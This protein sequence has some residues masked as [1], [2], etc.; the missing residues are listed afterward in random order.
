MEDRQMSSDYQVEETKPVA[1]A[2]DL[3]L[4]VLN[5]L[6]SPARNAFWVILALAVAVLVGLVFCLYQ[7]SLNNTRQLYLLAG[8]TGYLFFASITGAIIVRRGRVSLAVWLVLVSLQVVIAL[9]PL[10][11][12]GLGLWYALLVV[13]LTLGFTSLCMPPQRMIL[14]NILG[15]VAALAILVIDGFVTGLQMTPDRLFGYFLI[16]GV[17]ILA[18]IDLLI[19]IGYFPAYSLRAKIT[20]TVFS[21]AILSIGLLS[22]A[23][24]I[25]TRRALID[26]TDQTLMLAARETARDIDGYFL[27]LMDRLGD[28]AVAPIWSNFLSLPADQRTSEVTL[29]A[30]VYL[31]TQRSLAGAATYA[32]VDQQGRVVLYTLEEDVS[33]V[34]P[35]LGLPAKVQNLLMQTM[36]SGEVYISPV[37]FPPTGEPPFFVVAAQIRNATEQPLGILVASFTLDALQGIVTAGN[38][39]AGDG[40]YAVLFDENNLRIAHGRDPQSH[41]LLLVPPDLQVH[42]NLVDAMRIPNLSYREVTTNYLDFGQGLASLDETPYFATQDSANEGETNSAAAIRLNYRPWVLAFLQPQSVILAPVI[43]Q[44]RIT[45]LLAAVV[46][47]LAILAASLLARLVAEPIVR[48]TSIAER[49]AGG[50]LYLQASVQSPDEI[51]TLGSAFNS[52]IN[53]LRHT[54]EGLESRVKDRTTELVDT[55]QQM[56]YRANRL[57]MVADVAHAIAAVQDPRALL[58]RVTEEIS[59]R[60]G[61]YHVGVF[62]IDAERKFAVLQAANSP[63]GKRMLARNHRLRVGEVGI[64]G[65]VAGTGQARIALDVGKDA[66][67]FTNPD[68]PDTR[69]EISLPLKV[70]QEV[71]GVLDVQ[72]VVAGAFSQD[73][74]ALLSALA[75]QV[76]MAIQNTR[77]Y[78]ETRRTLRELQVVQRQY[79]QEMWGK[80]TRE[81]QV[82][83]FEV[84]FGQINPLQDH[85]DGDLALADEGLEAFQIS[86][87]EKGKMVIP[88][89]L[90]GQVIGVIDLQ[91]SGPGRPWSREEIELARA[92]ADQVGLALENARLLEETQRRAERER[93]VA[94]ITTKMRATNDPQ[95]IMETALAE[96]RSALGIKSIQVRLQTIEANLSGEKESGDG[97]KEV[98][99]EVRGDA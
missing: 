61:Y 51:G 97:T 5:R 7:A 69:S 64:V 18:V 94:D 88:I 62:L 77:L 28:Q 30:R 9:S 27:E 6:A 8:L 71:I 36:A 19:L 15:V 86:V 80:M 56:E 98:D 99:P 76:A 47:G 93:M 75:D 44:T 11:V 67:F 37:T 20:F 63:G 13:M 35:L 58:P 38:D 29:P 52:M 59:A 24:N 1:N 17:A 16:G 65:Y 78:D 49:A 14:A 22:I 32:L 89:G 87:D 4:R 68:L 84:T 79:L 85:G 25:S 40:S 39:T 43:A 10:L 70:G 90:R 96:L 45:I 23:N 54:L 53:Q 21:A 2:V 81:R 42:Q 34:P 83:G 95:A 72:S 60:Y 33:R 12:A 74:I 66:V 57:Q 55:S 46:T 48:L 3:R 26:A 73:D 91:E 41:Y 50:N 92:V 82:S 31:L